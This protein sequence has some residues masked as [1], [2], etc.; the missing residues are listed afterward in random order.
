MA[1]RRDRTEEKTDKRQEAGVMPIGAPTRGDERPPTR[2]VSFKA[3]ADVLEALSRLENA[4][5]SSVRAKRS[6]AVRK[7]VLEAAS[8]LREVPRSVEVTR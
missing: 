6:V 5:D 2:T 1:R 3:D 8:A 7:A 4:L